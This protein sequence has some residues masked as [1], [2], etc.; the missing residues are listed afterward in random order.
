MKDD[1]VR[2]L[3]DG[4]QQPDNVQEFFSRTQALS[5]SSEIEAQQ[6]ADAIRG[7]EDVVD[8][9]LWPV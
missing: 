9:D 6:S 4:S 5:M 1:P 8:L 2:S 3:L 7:T